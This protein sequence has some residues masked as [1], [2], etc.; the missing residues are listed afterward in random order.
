VAIPA[1]GRRKGARTPR[2]AWTIEQDTVEPD[3]ERKG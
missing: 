3:G 1:A 2:I